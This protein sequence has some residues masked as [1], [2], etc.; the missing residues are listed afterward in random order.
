MSSSVRI[1]SLV[2][3]GPAAGMPQ[4]RALWQRFAELQQVV[5]RHLPEIAASVFARPVTPPGCTDTVEWYSDLAG[6]PVPLLDLPG[7]EQDVLRGLLADRL[8]AISLLADA[9]ERQD[10]EARGLADLLR[11]A[12]RFPG[13]GA[14]YAIGG[15]PV[16]ISWG[17]AEAGRPKGDAPIPDQSGSAS[18]AWRRWMPALLGL[19]LLAVLA[20]GAWLWLRRAE[21]QDLRAALAVALAKQCDPTAPLAEL[22]AWLDRIDPDAERYPDIRMAVSTELGLCDDAAAFAERLAAPAACETLPALAQALSA[23]DLGRPP[24]ASLQAELG[25]RQVACRRVQGLEQDLMAAVGDCP[26]LAALDRDVRSLDAQTYPLADLRLDLDRALAACRLATDLRPRIG[27][28]GGDC[29]ALRDLA[30]EA[31]PALAGHDTTRAPLKSI[32]DGLDAE[33]SRCDLADHLEGEL[34]RSQ[35]DC[36]KLAG[37]KETLAGQDA[38]PLAA[39]RER[40]DL[41]LSHCAALTDLERRFAEAVGDCTRLKALVEGLEEYRTNLRFL[42]IRTRLQAELEVC[43]AAGALEERIADAGADCAKVR[44]I[45]GGIGDKGDPR[46]AKAHRG[47]QERIA[48]CDRL[49]R[50]TRLLVDAGTDCGKL[51]ALGRDLKHESAASLSAT[52]RRLDAALEPCKPRPQ[53]VTAPR[54]RP[55]PAGPGQTPPPPTAKAPS[56]SSSFAMRGGCTGQLV[57]SPSSGWDGDGIR[58]MVRI[59][60]PANARV[61]RV[62][63]T[64]R[65]CRNCTLGKV[66]TNLWRGDMYYRC[67]GR[68]IVPVSYAAYDAA[69]NLICSGNGSDLCLGRR[70]PAGVLR[71]IFGF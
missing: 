31:N 21:E 26:S 39:L 71:S 28:A 41:G 1:A 57:L 46:F 4:T 45:A 18:R 47:L 30:R 27:A 22:S 67:S 58:H 50:Y 23:Y 51:K 36:L 14:V 10:P 3:P 63:S 55:T 54:P 66:G 70:S 16:L 52:R 24:F 6:Q 5:R 35:G 61:A 62:T 43:S 32:R 42:D 11:Q 48:D 33:L 8:R 40:I 49:D 7:A 29:T 37:L 56:G 17:G 20:S 13:D 53:V 9:I 15:A 34:V 44:A 59:D 2:Y 65:G 68:G 38:A 25:A 19:I 60:P 64:N 69:G 12:I